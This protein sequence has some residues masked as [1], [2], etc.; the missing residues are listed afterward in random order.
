MAT[1]KKQDK[2]PTER[3]LKWKGCDE[4]KTPEKC[5]QCTHNRYLIRAI[6][7][8]FGEIAKTRAQWQKIG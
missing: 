6:R 8:E 7:G 4:C 2:K 5:R 3:K 1:K